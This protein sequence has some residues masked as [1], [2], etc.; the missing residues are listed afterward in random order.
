MNLNINSTVDI[1]R[2]QRGTVPHPRPERPRYV[3]DTRQPP[4]APG[5]SRAGTS[6]PRVLDRARGD[7]AR[8]RG[9]RAILWWT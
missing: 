2:R 7:P 9:V 8:G 6:A 1:E 5:P 4:S 3:S